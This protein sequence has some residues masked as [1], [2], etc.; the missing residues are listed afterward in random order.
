META[1]LSFFL[2]FFRFS[3]LFSLLFIMLFLL[4]LFIVSW[5]RSDSKGDSS[6]LKYTK[7]DSKSQLLQHQL[8]QHQQ[9]QFEVIATSFAHRVAETG[10]LMQELLILES[11]TPS[12]T[13]STTSSSS[14]SHTPHAPQTLSMKFPQQ[15]SNFSPQALGQIQLSLCTNLSA[16]PPLSPSQASCSPRLSFDDAPISSSKHIVSGVL[17]N[18]TTSSS[19]T[20]SSANSAHSAPC[21]WDQSHV[22]AMQHLLMMQ[23]YLIRDL[24]QSWSER[25]ALCQSLEKEKMIHLTSASSQSSASSS[26]NNLVSGGGGGGGSDNAAAMP[27]K[28]T[29]ESS[30]SKSKDAFLSPASSAG[31]KSKSKSMP[32]VRMI[33]IFTT[34]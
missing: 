6:K 23:Q 14:S 24:Y 8:H 10:Q 15:Q 31:E 25:N 30:K 9:Q 27:T 7:S 22:S 18:L 13:P 17:D 28:L 4:F 16:S 26:S 11:P 12:A 19:S 21:L 33:F 5:I 34:L 3:I 29:R 32:R 1:F 2:S 20:N